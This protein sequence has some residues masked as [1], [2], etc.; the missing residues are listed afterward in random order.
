M[1][2]SFSDFAKRKKKCTYISSHINH[3]WLSLFLT[4]DISVYL[5]LVTL[6][7][8]LPFNFNC[9]VHILK[10]NSCNLF[11]SAYF[12]IMLFLKYIFTRYGILHRFYFILNSLK[13]VPYGYLVPPPWYTWCL[14][15]LV[16][17]FRMFSLYL[18]LK[19][20]LCCT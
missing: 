11:L 1:S 19:V 15:Y 16:V 18:F 5:L 9:S 2:L 13:M 6:A 12:F 4:L 20:W 10:M 14:I 17:A 7:W 3:D 8:K